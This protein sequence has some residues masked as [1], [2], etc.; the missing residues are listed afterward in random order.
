MVASQRL[1]VARE[2]CA[3]VFAF[4]HKHQASDG[5]ISEI[6]RLGPSINAVGT[7]IILKSFVP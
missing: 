2:G 4:T 7:E 1:S 3:V 5:A 6:N